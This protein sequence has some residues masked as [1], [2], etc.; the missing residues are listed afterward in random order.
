MMIIYL[1]DLPPPVNNAK[2]L[3]SGLCK[4]LLPSMQ[5]P[6]TTLNFK[7]N[8]KNYFTRTAFKL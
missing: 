4:Q 8:D 6:V 5:K 1:D 3:F 7:L 2:K